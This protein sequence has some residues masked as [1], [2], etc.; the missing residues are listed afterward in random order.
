MTRR[1]TI[2]AVAVTVVAFS[3]GCSRDGLKEWVHDSLN[4]PF[5]FEKDR[6]ALV[7]LDDLSKDAKRWENAFVRLTCKFNRIE[8]PT[9]LKVW[10]PLGADEYINFSAFDASRDPA[11]EGAEPKGAFPMLFLS[12]DLALDSGENRALARLQAIADKARK[13]QGGERYPLVCVKGKVV[14][15]FRN[16]AWVEIDDLREVNAEKTPPAVA[17]AYDSG[18]REAARGEFA[19]A[20]KSYRQALGGNPPEGVQVE[21]LRDRGLVQL[22]LGNPELAER[23]LALAESW[24]MADTR[25]LL[26]LAEARLR[27]GRATEA[28]TTLGGK[29]GLLA[30]AEGKDLK[31]ACRLFLT[32]A[33]DRPTSVRALDA[34]GEGL[35]RAGKATEAIPQ[36]LHARMATGESPNSL[37]ELHLAQ[38]YSLAGDKDRAKGALERVKDS[39]GPVA[40]A[41]RTLRESL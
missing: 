3:V 27:M 37:V 20:D 31:A 33:G 30:T 14:S 6:Y 23:D 41:A 32:G 2:V 9:N 19:A 16:V 1:M 36:L 39:E 21:I 10:T 11:A 22:N 5:A 4:P 24:G 25:V 15:T 12:K 40:D 34:M 17:V 8:D 29:S 18:K 7:S 13:G 26:G 28:E 35:L 38:A